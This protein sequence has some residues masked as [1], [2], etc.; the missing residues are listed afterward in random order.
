[1]NSLTRISFLLCL[2]HSEGQTDFFFFLKI[3]SY[4]FYLCEYIF[5]SHM[6]ESARGDQKRES[7]SL[8]LSY[9]QLSVP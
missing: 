3:R 6:Y 9:R 5:V 2:S 8:E 4:F 1:M 7:N